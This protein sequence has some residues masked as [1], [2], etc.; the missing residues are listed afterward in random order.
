MYGFIYVYI[1]C[2]KI[3]L[4]SGNILELLTRYSHL[5]ACT[6]TLSHMWPLVVNDHPWNTNRYWRKGSLTSRVPI[7]ESK[8]TFG[9]WIV[10]RVL[11]FADIL[12][13]SCDRK[14]KMLLTIYT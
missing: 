4:I 7:G 10:K 5:Y 1:R 2:A 8:L 13:V 11:V 6:H 12:G 14:H 9:W 3:Y